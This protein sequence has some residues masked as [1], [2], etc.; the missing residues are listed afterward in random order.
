MVE[1]MGEGG[2]M[3][4]EGVGIEEVGEVNDEEGGEEDGELMEM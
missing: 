4:D 1:E 2:V 3:G